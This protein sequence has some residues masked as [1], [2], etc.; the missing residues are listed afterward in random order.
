MALLGAASA[1]TDFMAKWKEVQETIVQ[2][3]KGA[4]E[5]PV[6]DFMTKWAGVKKTIEAEAKLAPVKDD[7]KPPPT[8]EEM[9]AA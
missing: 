7:V 9:A 2:E 5:A 8:L 6:A 3:A 1:E 4:A